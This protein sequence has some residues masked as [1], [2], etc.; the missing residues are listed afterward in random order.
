MMISD[1]SRS[2][3]Y[4]AQEAIGQYWMK[5][6]NDGAYRHEAYIAHVG[7]HCDYQL[8]CKC[9]NHFSGSAESDNVI[10]LT[11]SRVLFF[12]S[13]KL[14][15][16]WEL[17]FS[18]VQGVTVEDTGIRFSHKSDR[19][20]DR[21]AFIPDKSSQTWFF[22]QVASVVKTYNARKRMDV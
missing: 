17:P 21:F 20:Q 6:L 10:L 1:F 15:L 12:W 2:K 22:N 5:D 9:T 4:S 16:V 14:R 19:G 3:S 13:R 8:P 7:E 18:Q 11:Q